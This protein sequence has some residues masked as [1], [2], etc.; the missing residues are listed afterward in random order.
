VKF[1]K[2]GSKT[3]ED[4][5]GGRD[6]ESLRKFVKESLEVACQI[7]ETSGCDE[8]EKE[9]IAQMRAKGDAATELPRL[10]K[11]LQKSMKAD[12]KAWVSKRVNILKQLSG[13][14]DL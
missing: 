13:K 2:D 11:M 14:T 4:Y 7:D 5:K 8:K 1:F 10:E 6:L 9:Y 12:L 3:G